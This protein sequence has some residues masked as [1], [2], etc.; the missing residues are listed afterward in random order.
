MKLAAKLTLIFVLLSIGPLSIVSYLAYLNGRHAIEQD[1][2]DRLSTITLL[3]EAELNQWLD[4]N[5]SDIQTSAQRPLVRQ[6]ATLLAST[7]STTAATQTHD[8]LIQNHFLPLQQQYTSFLELTLLRVPDGL[9]LAS[10]DSQLEGQYLPTENVFIEGQK[11][12][13][14]G[15][16]T[17]W[18]ALDE[19][20]MAIS[21][22]VAGENGTVIAVLAT[23]LDLKY[24][25][26]IMAR[27][28]G[29]NATEE[30]YLG[31]ASNTMITQSLLELTSTLGR[32]VYTNGVNDCLAQ[33]DGGGFYNDY[34]GVP[35]IGAYRWMPEFELCIVTEIDQREALAPIWDAR[36]SIVLIGAVVGVGT[37][38]AGVFFARTLSTPL[39]HL[40]QGTKQ[41]SRGNLDYRVG[42]SGRDEISQLSRAFDHMAE[43]L[44]ATTISR[45]DLEQRVAERT[46]QLQESNRELE[47]FSYSV[48]HDLRSPLRAMDGFSRIVLEDYASDLPGE[49]QRYLGLVRDNAQQMGSLIDHLLAFSRLGRQPLT[50]E[51]VVVSDLVRSVLAALSTELDGQK[52]E[53]TIGDLPPCQADPALLR[54]VFANLLGN[55]LK[56]AQ[57]RDAAIIEV[58]CDNHTGKSVY[59]VKDNGV[60]FDM[61]YA[62]KLFG[63]FQR[64]HRAE[65]YPGTG[66][67]LATVQRIIHRHGGRIW[68]EAEPDKGATFYFTIEG[69]DAQ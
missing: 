10:T 19:I 69:E 41:I 43:A 50:K 61:R 60:G 28:T 9:V 38:V 4:G 52:V 27:R 67:G 6:Y 37:I 18:E 62:N 65:D 48:S 26:N 8:L 36:N 45:D 29:L 59:F 66:V 40:V 54:Q 1:A 35:V 44:R 14:L 64:L 55:A 49:A 63:V 20:V 17:Y 57:T 56:F 34:R 39:S 22:P 24:I 51:P 21:T 23:H 11:A 25:S 33:H 58:G 42:L 46:A 16:I 30:T 7:G 12:T 53:I 3:K 5:R 68:A 13:Y 15:D 47:A 2:I 31:N 32:S